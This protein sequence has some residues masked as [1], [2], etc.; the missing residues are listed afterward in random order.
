MNVHRDI[1]LLENYRQGEKKSVEIEGEWNHKNVCNA[2]G[3]IRWTFADFHTINEAK[4]LDLSVAFHYQE[5]NRYF[6]N[7][8]VHHVDLA[9][10]A[11][12]N[13]CRHNAVS[14]FLWKL[15]TFRLYKSCMSS[16][17]PNLSRLSRC[18]FTTLTQYSKL[19][20]AQRIKIYDFPSREVANNLLTKCS[21]S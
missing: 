17:N 4:D 16:T 18:L 12:W 3:K 15:A 5:K 10:K 14:W 7:S 21:T 9:G 1:S 11:R 13:Y 20:E 8:A 6:H 2:R 19:F